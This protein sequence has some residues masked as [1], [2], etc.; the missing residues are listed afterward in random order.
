M[1]EIS[2][3]LID[4]S[5]VPDF[6]SKVYWV[7]YTTKYNERFIALQEKPSPWNFPIINLTKGDELSL[8]NSLAEWERTQPFYE[9]FMERVCLCL[10]YCR[11]KTNDELKEQKND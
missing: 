5:K 2:E 7:S 11:N 3:Q 1:N 10:N 8:N 9:S 6:W 4:F